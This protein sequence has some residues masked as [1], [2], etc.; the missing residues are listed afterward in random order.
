MSR[1]MPRTLV[2]VWWTMLCP[3]F[4][5]S[6]EHTVSHSHVVEWISGSFIQSHWPC[7][8]LWPISMFSRILARP[9]NAVPR[10]TAGTRVFF[11]WV[12]PSRATR[13][14]AASPRWIL[15]IRLMYAASSLLR[16]SSIC[17]RIASSSRPSCSTS[18]SVRWVYSLTSEMAMD[19]SFLAGVERRTLPASA[20]LMSSDV[21]G[22]VADGGGDAGL[23]GLVRL[24]ELVAA[25]QVA[26][27]ALDQT[28]GAGVADAHPATE[29]HPDAGLLTGLQ[30][31]GGAVG[32]DRLPGV[33]ERDRA[34][35]TVALEIEREPF[36][37]QLV[38]NPGVLEVLLDGVEHRA[39]TA[40]PGLALAP[41]GADL[42]EVSQVQHAVDV[43]VQLVQREPVVPVLQLDQLLTEDHPVG[44][45]GGVVHDDVR[46]RAP[47]V[48]G[49]QHGHHRR[50]TA[51][52]DE[53]EHPLGGRVRE[54]EV[55]LRHGEPD[56][57]AG[58]EAVDEVAGEQAL[59]HRTHRDR[60][61]P[62]MALGRRADRV[63]APLELPLDLH[64]DPDVLPGAV[65]VL[66]S[67]A[68][69]D[70]QRGGVVGLADDLLD[71]AAQLAGGPEG[72]D[73]AQVVVGVQRRGQLAAD[74][75]H[76]LPGN[77][78]AHRSGAP[79]GISVNR[80]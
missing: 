58:R 53:E 6:A 79:R 8:T 17:V 39:G 59:R 23:H 57:R 9:R 72:I 30:D 21:Q 64:P 37:V 18:S 34:T 46:H 75:P 60:N 52:R 10:T 1:S 24:P 51:A 76:P 11:D 65:L 78:G 22:A 54:H 31:R 62:S 68:R 7:I 61:G 27:R 69:A 74:L 77:G 70:H 2:Q 71:P 56:D 42:V 43:G 55:P 13:P 29:G 12:P 16:D 50:D 5:W 20:G 35:L 3:C 14:A 36:Q 67:P 19:T 15:I 26:D 48:Q 28:Q 66:P 49:A 63:G 44:S 25:A 47:P 38:A 45:G 33:L 41:V 80:C 40:G 4:Q 73:E 32:I